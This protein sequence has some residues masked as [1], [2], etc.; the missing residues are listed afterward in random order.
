MVVNLDFLNADAAAWDCA[1]EHRIAYDEEAGE[2]DDE[3][4]DLRLDP[5]LR[6]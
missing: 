6:R 4:D 3:D 2:E 5:M 1:A